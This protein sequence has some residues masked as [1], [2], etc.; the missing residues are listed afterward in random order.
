MVFVFF[1]L[2]AFVKGFVVNGAIM[3]RITINDQVVDFDPPGERSKPWGFVEED[4][5]HG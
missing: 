5:R 3:Q 4:G 2:W 1:L